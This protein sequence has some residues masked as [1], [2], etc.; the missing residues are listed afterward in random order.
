MSSVRLGLRSA[1]YITA[2]RTGGSVSGDLHWDWKQ[3]S[4]LKGVSL[5]SLLGS[6]RAF[7]R[8]A[9]DA[10]RI[11]AVVDHEEV[12]TMAV[13]IELEEVDRKGCAGRSGRE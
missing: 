3:S 7:V 2:N 4:E 13:V 12:C 6:L 11:T 1:F 8:A 10:S 9:I 5:L